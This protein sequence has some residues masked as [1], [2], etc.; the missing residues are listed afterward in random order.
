MLNI[1]QIAKLAEVS[2]TTV[3]RVLNDHPYV[4]EDKRAAVWRVIED[5]NYRT[6]INAVHLSKGKTFL[7]G[8][9]L[10][11]ANHPYFGQLIEGIS[12]EAA[13]NNYNLVLFQTN[14]KIIKEIEALNMLKHKQ[15]DALIICS[16]ACEWKTIKDYTSYGAIVLFEDVK[17]ANVS[18]TFVDHYKTFTD[19]LNFL[20][21]KGHRKI[22]Y[23]VGRRSGTNSEQ[24]ESAYRDFL[25]KINRPFFQEYIFDH[26]LYF[27]DGEQVMNRMMKMSDP[28]SALVVTSDQV[29]AGILTYCDSHNI[30]VPTRLALI[31]FDNQPI[32][33]IMGITTI[34]ISL[35]EIGKRL[36][37]Q[38]VNEKTISNE[39]MPSKLIERHTV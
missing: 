1:R 31:G 23:C 33:K 16:R 39:E 21:K 37:H 11:Y 8:L 15:V 19:A 29:T 4:S 3:S 24:R 7:I 6:N 17:G 14:Y 34:D 5:N 27:E 13:E 26:C 22:G 25:E 35:V 30:P 18:S 32:A 36:F 28:P 10:P 38:A 20:Y 2:A 9:V 12:R